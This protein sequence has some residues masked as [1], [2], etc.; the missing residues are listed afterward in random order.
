MQGRHILARENSKDT[1]RETLDVHGCVRRVPEWQR[2]S[3]TADANTRVLALKNHQHV[4]RESK[5][6]P[7]LSR[8]FNIPGLT[9]R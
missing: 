5:R 1:Y 3:A 2:L 9:S 4:P 7:T 6:D 8:R